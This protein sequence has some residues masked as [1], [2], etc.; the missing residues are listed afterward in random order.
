MQ[1]VGPASVV[2][3]T[4]DDLLQIAIQ[5]IAIWLAVVPG[6]NGGKEFS[7]LLDE[8]SETEHEKSTLAAGH[9]P[10]G[11]MVERSPGSSD[12]LVNVLCA[13]SFD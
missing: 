4:I 8:V 11:F 3:K 5:G 13:R 12:S 2:A 9:V 10:P 1:L 6:L 7:V